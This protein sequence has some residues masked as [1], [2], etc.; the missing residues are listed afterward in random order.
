M[1]SCHW[2]LGRKEESLR[3]DRDVYA[4]RMTLLGEAHQGTLFAAY[5]L[6]TRLINLWDRKSQAEAKALLREVLPR[7]ASSLGP[8][9]TG[10]LR[11]RALYAYTLWIGGHREGVIMKGDAPV[12]ATL[13]DLVEAVATYEDIMPIWLRRFGENHPETLNLR[14]EQ[15]D[16]RKALADARASSEQL[17]FAAL[18]FVAA[19]AFLVGRRYL[20]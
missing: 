14:R 20:R 1:A 16:A 7:A 6:A 13:D 11:L 2:K 3:I 10:M 19:V 9:H 5:S 4:E 17:A 12:A 15:A 8:E 18:A